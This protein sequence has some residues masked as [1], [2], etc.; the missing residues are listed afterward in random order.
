M[1]IINRT[2]GRVLTTALVAGVVAAAIGGVSLARAGDGGRT[3]TLTEVQTNAAFVNISHTPQGAPG[4]QLILRSA[5][6]DA[7]GRRIGSSSVV[8]EMVFAKQL[9]C[10][11]VYRL[12]GGTL[13]GTA[14]APASPTSTAPVHIAITGGT[15][16]YEGASGQATLTPQSQT[17]NHT[18]IDLD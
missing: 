12:P 17:V 7:Q 14:M 9:Q 15:G 4:D 2:T 18:V 1:R 8:C 10:T 16:R 13:T 11:G 5:V 6:K 3:L